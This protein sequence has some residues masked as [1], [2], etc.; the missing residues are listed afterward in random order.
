MG[1]IPQSEPEKYYCCWYY[2]TLLIR[3]EVHI[4]KLPPGDTRRQH[5]G[6]VYPTQTRHP[7]GSV[8]HIRASQ[9]RLSGFA[10]PDSQKWVL[11]GL[12]R[13]GK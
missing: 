12:G 4:I 8:Y 13:G 5:V 2:N 9:G 1:G 3:N 7:T 10:S 11:E 6:R